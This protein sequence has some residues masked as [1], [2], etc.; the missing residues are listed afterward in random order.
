[1]KF[2][3]D[4]TKEW[5]QHY[6]DHG[7]AHL[8]GVFGEEFITPALAEVRR[9]MGNESPMREWTKENAKLTHTP[10]NKDFA[11]LDG[12][13]DQPGIRKMIDVMFAPTDTWNGERSYQLFVT[14]FDPGDGFGFHVSGVAG[15]VGAVQ[16]ESDGLSGHA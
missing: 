8:T 3:V 5:T 4:Q 13:Y 16:R 9:L 7:Y 10:R 6:I 14:P 11:V 2:T 1:M 12:I 15:E